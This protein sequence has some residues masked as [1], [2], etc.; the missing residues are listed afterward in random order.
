MLRCTEC[1]LEFN[2]SEFTSEDENGNGN[3]L[4]P[5]C[6]NTNCFEEM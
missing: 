3:D 5:A 4:C 1:G 6:N 2:E